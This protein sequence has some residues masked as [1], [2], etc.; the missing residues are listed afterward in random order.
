MF[1][2][3]KGVSE[4]TSTSIF[5]AV[6]RYYDW[7]KRATALAKMETPNEKNQKLI[8]DSVIKKYAYE[9][10]KLREIK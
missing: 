1:S 2:C 5:Q 7:Q 9:K 4:M 6:K 10:K 3:T 8:I